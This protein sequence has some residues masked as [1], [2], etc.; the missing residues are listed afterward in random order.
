MF[1]NLK[2]SLYS[3]SKFVVLP[4]LVLFW[5]KEPLSFVAKAQEAP[6]FT[7]ALYDP[8]FKYRSNVCDRYEQFRAGEVDF[9]DALEGLEL[10]AMMGAGSLFILREDGTIDPQYPGFMGVLM[11]ELALR[12]G[13]T[14]RNSFGVYYGP[15]ENKTYTDLAIWGTDAYDVL[16]DWWITTVDRLQKG[17]G[18]PEGFYDASFVLIGRKGTDVSGNLEIFKFLKPFDA[19]LWYTILATI[20]ASALAYMAIEGASSEDWNVGWNFY[21]GVLMFCQ[22]FSYEP[23][24]TPGRLFGASMAFWSMLIIVAYTANLASFFVVQNA[25]ELQINSIDDA[26]KANMRICTW[27]TAASDGYARAQYPQGRFIGKETEEESLLGV[28]NDECDLCLMSLQSWQRYE[29]DREYNGDCDLQWIGRVV[30]FVQGSLAFKND[31]GNLCTSLIQD[32]IHTHLVEM[33][34]DGF[35]D[36]AWTDFFARSQDINCSNESG[37]DVDPLQSLQLTVKQMAGTFVVH[38]FFGAFALLMTAAPFLR[39]RFKNTG[40]GETGNAEKVPTSEPQ[41]LLGSTEPHDRDSYES[42]PL[43]SDLHS[44]SDLHGHL[45]NLSDA[46][47]SQQQEI[48][49]MMALLK[50]MHQKQVNEER[51]QS[52]ALELEAEI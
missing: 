8:I 44:L 49:V 15:G 13:F 9:R 41:N 31:A 16:V 17:I 30:H 21:L 4:L 7:T 48:K 6:V 12:A 14:W 33:K 18:F 35:I 50:E 45:N 5:A 42:S 28:K 52:Q 22:H 47:K 20:I 3:S 34:V 32:V 23:K 10:K 24:S 38:A 37:N 11:D 25:S 19:T 46:Q 39:R 2:M 1:R 40:G 29:G 27:A 36:K 43:F 51:S 26:I